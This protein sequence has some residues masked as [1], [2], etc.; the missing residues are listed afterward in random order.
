MGALLRD[1]LP[2]E[3][4]HP[5]GSMQ[6]LVELTFLHKIPAVQPIAVYITIINLSVAATEHAGILVAIKI[7]LSDF[8]YANICLINEVIRHYFL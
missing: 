4:I 5:D 7:S 1:G 2:C 8:L 6:P 3:C